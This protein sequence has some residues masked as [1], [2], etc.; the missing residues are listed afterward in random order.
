MARELIVIGHRGAMGYAPENTLA[1]FRK[2]LELGT[3]FVELDVYFV[4][5]HLL[6]FHDERLER[7]TNGQGLLREQT[8]QELRRLD[9]G[10]GE[11]IPTLAEV[12][13]VIGGRAGLNIELKGSATAA[14]VVKFITELRRAGFA[15]ETFLVSSF[16]RELLGHVRKLDQEILLGV[17]VDAPRP[18][19]IS[20]ATELKAHAVCPPMAAVNRSLVS[21]AHLRGL[22]IYVFTVNEPHESKRMVDLGVDGVFSNYPDLVMAA[23]GPAKAEL[24]SSSAQTKLMPLRC[25]AE[26]SC[27]SVHTRLIPEGCKKKISWL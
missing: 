26:L 6:V 7:T 15:N 19:H 20:F 1:S 27:S 14:P 11:K 9:A 21:E 3:C 23:T 16:N 2:A 24:S 22:K 4:D 17:L 18:D 25:K 10:N 5:G 8:F 13:E 12:F